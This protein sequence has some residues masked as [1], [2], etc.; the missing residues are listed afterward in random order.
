VKIATLEFRWGLMF[1]DD[2][3]IQACEDK[4]FVGGRS[5]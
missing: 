1:Q 3:S 5:S 4:G 2:D